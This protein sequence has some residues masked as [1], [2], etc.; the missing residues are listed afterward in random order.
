MSQIITKDF[1]GS[2][3]RIILIEDKEFFIAKDVAELLGY[4]RTR[5][6]IAQHCKNDVSFDKIL[7]VS[8]IDTLDLQSILGNSW[9][10]TKVIPESDV[11][12]LIL[13]SKKIT[14][15][16]KDELISFLNLTKLTILTSRKEVEFGKELT[17]FIK[18]IYDFN[19]IYQYQVLTYRIDFYI[20]EFN[21]A[22]EFDEKSHKV[23]NVNIKD[24]LREKEIS[25]FLKCGFVRVSEE[26][27]IG[28]Q[29]GSVMKS[30]INLTKKKNKK[31]IRQEQILEILEKDISTKELSLKFNVS[32]TTILRD[33]KELRK[34]NNILKI[35][36]GR[37]IFYKQDKPKIF[38]KCQ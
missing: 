22:I 9:Q 17:D 8:K 1:H 35:R 20:K 36:K 15:K 11:L 4:K 30:I 26:S 12:R 24:K 2:N 38:L 3:L 29:L 21:L 32:K 14:I 18:N 31:E 23:N 27:S 7:E 19:V 6:A 34:T 25:K 13:K 10:Q 33:L 28:E 16:F 37:N 5:D